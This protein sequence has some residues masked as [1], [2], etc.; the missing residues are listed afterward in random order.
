[1][2]TVQR[3]CSFGKNQT[4]SIPVFGGSSNQYQTLGG[5]LRQTM[6]NDE[7]EDQH[8]RVASEL[9]VDSEDMK[10]HP[11]DLEVEK[12]GTLLVHWHD[13]A[14]DGVIREGD[15]GSYTT[16]IRP[17]NDSEPQSFFEKFVRRSQSG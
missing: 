1:M 16:P 6:P 2:P 10:D 13:Q 14:P 4:G 12:S 8:A 11:Y 9:G 15:L 5:A 17:A 7:I 3:E